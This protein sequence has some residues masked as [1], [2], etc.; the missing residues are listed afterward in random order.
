MISKQPISRIERIIYFILFILLWAYLWLRAI[1]V[2]LV[3]DEIAT[4]Y[5]YIQTGRFLPYLS[6]WDAN[7]H[8][9][10]SALTWLSYS[11]SGCMNGRFV[12]QTS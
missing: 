11:S 4:F 10:N 5:H 6:H 9:L 7:N 1:Y 2:P 3:H 12:Y 8:F